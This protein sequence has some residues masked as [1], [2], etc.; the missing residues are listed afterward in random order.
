[1]AKGFKSEIDQTKAGVAAIAVCIA[2][3]L[4]ESDPTIPE[5]LKPRLD[6]WY[7]EL[8]DR[9]EPHGAELMY[10]F[11]RALSDPELFAGATD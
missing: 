8:S 7:H 10:M 4:A 11:R 6:H 9:G 1:M 2:Q 3:T 5:R